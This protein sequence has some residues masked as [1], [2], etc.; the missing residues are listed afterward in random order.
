MRKRHYA[1][2]VDTNKHSDNFSVDL[3]SYVTNIDDSE[4][5]TAVSNKNWIDE[6]IIMKMDCNNS[7]FESYSHSIPTPNWILLKDRFYQKDNQQS[8]AIF[9]KNKPTSDIIKQILERAIEFSKATINSNN[10]EVT[11]IRVFEISPSVFINNYDQEPFKQ[12]DNPYPYLL[13]EK[14]FTKIHNL[15]IAETE[16]EIIS[17]GSG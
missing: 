5:P 14:D 12:I 11:N 6:N 9:F 8:V 1:V 10:F 7:K 13:S 17:S 16:E 2:A 4:S 3:C 15:R